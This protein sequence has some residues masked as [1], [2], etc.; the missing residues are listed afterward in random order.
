MRTNSCLSTTLTIAILALDRDHLAFRCFANAPPLNKSRQYIQIIANVT[1]LDAEYKPPIFTPAQKPL[2]ARAHHLNY[3]DAIIP[4][5]NP[6]T[7]PRPP[8][9]TLTMNKIHHHQYQGTFIL[10]MSMTAG[11]LR[12]GMAS[13]ARNLAY[14]STRDSA[15]VPN[16]GIRNWRP[17]ARI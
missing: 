4:F 6:C 11:I 1:T 10:S 2:P 5:P 13:S 15:I 3:D 17:V 9:Q 12:I 7:L 14:A 16:F 8:M